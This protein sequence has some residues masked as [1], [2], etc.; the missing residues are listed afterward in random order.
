MNNA[1]RSTLGHLQHLAS[2]AAVSVA[3]SCGYETVDPIPQPAR[4]GTAD[5]QF[6]ATGVWQ[7]S[8]DAGT[9]LVLVVTVTKKTAG[10]GTLGAQASSD[11]GLQSMTVDQGT[12][13]ARL[14]FRTLNAGGGDNVYANVPLTCSAGTDNLHVSASW[15]AAPQL[16]RTETVNLS[17]Y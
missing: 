16:G 6:S 5:A 10:A 4:C 7:V 13:T 15:T 11:S 9:G 14:V 2:V 12:G 1:R 3:A 17:T 8:G